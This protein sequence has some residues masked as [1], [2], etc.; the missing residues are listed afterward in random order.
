M[1]IIPHSGAKPP[2][3]LFFMKSS[4]FAKARPGKNPFLNSIWAAWRYNKNMFSF[5]KK[6]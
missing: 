6:E 5:L 3:W 4:R 1:F 2:G